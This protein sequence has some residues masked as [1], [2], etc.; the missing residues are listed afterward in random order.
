MKSF[1]N[2][3]ILTLALVLLAFATP[4]Q[5]AWELDGNL[6][7]D[8]ALLDPWDPQVITGPDGGA[9]V[10]YV[11]HETGYHDIYAQRYDAWGNA[12]WGGGVPVIIEANEQ[13]APAVVGDGTG[14]LIVAWTD[15]RT[16]TYEGVYAQRLDSAGNRLWGAGGIQL[17]ATSGTGARIC[18]DHAGGA[19][20]SWRDTR[21]A[22]ADIYAQ[23]L[24]PTGGELWTAGG[25]GV[26]TTAGDQGDFVMA[27]NGMGGAFFVWDFDTGTDNDILGQLVNAGGWLEWHLYP[28]GQPIC[29]ATGDQW[30]PVVTADDNGRLITAWLDLRTGNYEVYAQLTNTNGAGIWAVDGVSLVTSI[31]GIYDPAIASDGAGGAIVVWDDGDLFAQR[32]D[33]EGNPL[34][35]SAGAVVCESYGSQYAPRVVPDG[36]GGAVFAWEDSRFSN[37]NVYAQRL[38]GT[39]APL[40]PANGVAVCS[41][42]GDERQP[43]LAGD[44]DGGGYLVWPDPRAAD[45][46]NDI[47][48][49]RVDRYGNWG[50]PCPAIAAVDDIPGDQGWAVNVAW[51]ASRLDPWPDEAIET[52]SLWRA[53][54]GP[55]KALPA[56]AVLV[57]LADFEPGN[58]GRIVR[59]DADP[60]KALYWEYL[61][62]LLA[63]NLPNYAQAL[64]TLFNLTPESQGYHHFQVVAHGPTPLGMGYW[65]SEPDTGRSIDNLAPAA[66][67]MVVGEQVY[68][69]TRLEITWEPN[70]EA[71]LSNYEVYRGTAPGFIPS[72]ANLV[73]SPVD[74][75]FADAGW[76][77]GG[78]YYKVSARDVHGNE[79]DHALL[80]PAE[81]SAAGDVPAAT[82]LAGVHPNPFNPQTTIAFTVRDPQRVTVAVFDVT[83]RRVAVLTDE[84]WPAGS[85]DLNWNGRDATGREM[86][87]GVYFVNFRARDTAVTE[88]V[89]LVR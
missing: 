84:V 57:D 2:S 75:A 60:D 87:S 3:T 59:K 10:V 72:T 61:G 56:G 65:I 48:V 11:A 34:W 53:L 7:H 16:G 83:G 67:A 25:F 12:L 43:R 49:Q 89:V 28:A 19:V 63:R 35:G 40:W 29:A 50:Y 41:A 45:Y 44:G 36:N 76:Q 62:D 70:V 20:V 27:S 24:S 86:S 82:A 23:R 26:C 81:V 78:Y 88:K 9:I 58:K 5:A 4:T 64:P 14:G 79:S 55:A 18:S 15:F 69:P 68:E 42:L 37:Y 8:P 52:Y 21:G 46:S 22:D 6:V 51:G 47:Y 66:P 31:G 77:A 17:V 38:S 1:A 74:P 30:S 71:D 85:H 13:Y 73:G 80:A 33:V 32:I 54:D 39:G